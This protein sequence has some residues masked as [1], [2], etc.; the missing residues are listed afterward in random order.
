MPPKGIL[1]H[2]ADIGTKTRNRESM[3]TNVMD[4][5]ARPN[6]MK[7]LILFKSVLKSKISIET[8]SDVD[9]N[10]LFKAILS[11]SIGILLI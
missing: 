4:N 11:I 7:E 6:I 8:V 3:K 10:D 9:A 2:I 1:S 5:V